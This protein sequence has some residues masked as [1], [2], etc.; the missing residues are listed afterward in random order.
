MNEMILRVRA[1]A[2]TEIVSSRGARRALAVGAFA[3]ATALGAQVE[4]LIGPVPLTLQ[5]LFVVLA[6]V[7][8]GAR[9]GAASQLAYLAAGMAGLPVFA[10]GAMGPAWLLGPTGGYLL[11]FP[12]AAFVA[13]TVAGPSRRSV[14]GGVRLLAGLLAGSMVVLAGGFGQ[15]AALTGDPVR[16]AAVGVAPFLLGDL[17]KVALAWLIAWRARGRTLG[18][19]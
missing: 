11:A 17:A 19:L 7:M 5:T 14:M 12:V 9:L 13:G 16:A 2:T 3:L 8:L 18:L 6:G 1:A 10:A 4:V 15:L